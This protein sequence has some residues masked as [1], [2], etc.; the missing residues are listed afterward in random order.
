[1]DA[2]SFMDT[3]LKDHKSEFWRF[4][5]TNALLVPRCEKLGM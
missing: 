4:A 3:T 1:M 2:S 5:V